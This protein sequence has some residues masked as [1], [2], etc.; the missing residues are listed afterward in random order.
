VSF[1]AFVA[2]LFDHDIDHKVPPGSER[3][4]AW[5]FHVDVEFDAKNISA[6]CVQMFGHPEFLLSR[7]TK[8]QLE[9]GFWAIQGPNLDCSVSR[10]IED[11]DLT[12]SV[13]EE[14]IRS[15]ADLFKRLFA[16][17]P[18][19]TSVKMWWDSLCYEWHCGNR[20]REHG[21]ENLELQN[22]YF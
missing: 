1:D 5:Y 19:D 9:E 3:Y 18:L 11:S 4:D 7:F 14:C 17:E 21:G 20:K 15:M 13:R 22:V 2:F 6:Y 12:L 8:P 10:L 16:R